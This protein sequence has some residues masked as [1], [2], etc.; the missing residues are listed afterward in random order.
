MAAKGVRRFRDRKVRL[1]FGSQLIWNLPTII[2]Q[3]Q[4]HINSPVLL[5]SHFTLFL[6]L[7]VARGSQMLGARAQE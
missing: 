1:K 4:T 5:V 6:V 3:D 7:S 2:F